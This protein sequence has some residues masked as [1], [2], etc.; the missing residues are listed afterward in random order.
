LP[1]LPELTVLAEKLNERLKGQSVQEVR[2][3]N[4]L[5]LHGHTVE[6][7]ESKALGNAFESFHADGKFLIIR[8]SKNDIVIN[9]MLTGRIRVY[10]RTRRPRAS[11]MFSLQAD[12]DTFWY[13][14]Q[15]KMG[16]VYITEK[17]DY[18]GVAGFEGRG[19]S[20]L[21]SNLTLP[22]FR[23]RIRHH[24]GQI[25][26]VLRNQRFVKGIGNAYADEILL[27]AGILPLRRR[28]TLS[29]AEVES[30]YHA[31]R[32][33]LGRITDILSKR[34]LTEIAKEN[35]DFMMVHNRGGGA[36]CPLCGG[37]ISE[38]SANRFKTSFC[39]TCQ[40]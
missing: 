8:M 20:A 19:P 14:D 26:N 29:D 2:I 15:K 18:S 4:H 35:R 10:R 7:F 16:R 11:D 1:E 37:R 27:Y 23:E 36:I 30:L 40:K 12:P 34:D 21:D 25:K 13:Q 31:M 5:V 17:G 24:R 9:P 22:I 33:V 28:S 39:Q 6:E 3:Y 38:I 32:K